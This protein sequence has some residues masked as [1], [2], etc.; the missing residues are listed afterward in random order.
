M[1]KKALVKTVAVVGSG[2]AGLAA[3][4]ALG[5]SSHRLCLYET[6][7]RLGGHAHAV[8]FEN[9]ATGKSCL[10]DT[11][12]MIFNGITY[13]SYMYLPALDDRLTELYSQLHR[14]SS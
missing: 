11:A 8:R 3:V 12:F 7:S 6:S 2:G 14:R 10:V 13:R 5:P 1:G 9:E 4:W